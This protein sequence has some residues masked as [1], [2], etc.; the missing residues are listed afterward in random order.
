MLGTSV[1]TYQI[2]RKLGQ[3][4]MGIVY[5]G[6][7][8]AIGRRVAIKVLHPEYAHDREVLNRFFNEARAANLIEHPAIITVSDF[9]HLANGSAYLVMEF[10]D[11]RTLVEYVDSVGGRLPVEQAVPIVVQVASALVA[12]H[13][14][15]VIHRDLKPSN[16]MLLADE[17]LPEGIRVKILDFGIAKLEAPGGANPRTRSGAVLG[18]PT[19]M[20]P[21]QC[22]SAGQV[23]GKA[24]VY[25]LGIILFELLAGQPPF[26]APSDLALLNMQVSQKAPSIREF[27]Q[28]VPGELAALLRRMLLKKPTDRPSMSDVLVLLQR[29]GSARS[30]NH[31]A[32]PAILA[33]IDPLG[34]TEPQAKLPNQPTTFN[35]QKELSRARRAR[36]LVSVCVGVLF[37]LILLYL[38]GRHYSSYETSAS[39]VF[40]VQ[41]GTD[42]A[43]DLGMANQVRSVASRRAAAL[44]VPMHARIEIDSTPRGAEIIDAEIDEVL[45]H[46]PWSGQVSVSRRDLGL[47]LRKD[48]HH[49]RVLRIKPEPGVFVQ[50]NEL[51]MPHRSLR[52]PQ[53][54]TKG[55]RFQIE[56]VK[57]R[58]FTNLDLGMEVDIPEIA[59]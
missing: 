35:E 51:L 41:R 59:D 28:R 21:E 10:L 33:Q 50:R 20:A 11:G 53:R 45:G 1:G 18:T 40:P 56:A 46:T 15:G 30:A 23:D 39:D 34:K 29:I 9:G 6:V 32:L 2:I 13:S 14:C 36:I 43:M 54:A 52:R 19:Y 5:E 38:S 57:D 16:V 3:G 26:S 49:D 47:V 37:A 55:K 4:G 25:A 58:F 7:Q 22:V 48:G 8:T 42:S 27:D 44:T 31:S 24:D 17:M 12:A